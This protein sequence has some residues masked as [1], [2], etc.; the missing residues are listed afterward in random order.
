MIPEKV[1]KYMQSFGMSDRI[2]EFETSSATVALA[3][4]AI[5]TQ[6]QRIAKTLAFKKDDGCILISAAGDMKIDNAKF[7]A[8]FGM[9]AKMLTPEETLLFTG[10][11]VG[12][13]CPFALPEGIEVYLD[14]SLKRFETVFPA[15]GSGNSAVE[16]TC[17]ELEQLSCASAWVNVC[18][19]NV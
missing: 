17:A 19:S 3:A 9:K 16:L 2:K 7:K 10:Y 6:P 14:E 18:K 12:G 1:V 4:A 8:A 15:A 11:A 5:G 13:V